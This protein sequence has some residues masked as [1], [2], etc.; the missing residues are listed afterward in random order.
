[1]VSA[2]ATSS[3]EN[4]CL[5]PNSENSWP[6]PPPFDASSMAVRVRA[7]TDDRA[8]QAGR[9]ASS[10]TTR[11]RHS[12]SD[13]RSWLSTR[14]VTRSLWYALRTLCK[15]PFAVSATRCAGENAILDFREEAQVRVEVRAA[16]IP[17]M[18]G[19]VVVRQHGVRERLVAEAVEGRVVDRFP[20]CWPRRRGGLLEG[21]G[22]R[23]DEE[24]RLAIAGCLGEMR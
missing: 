11:R 5:P 13:S 22:G 4:S 1:M 24:E 14:I 21:A 6:R 2:R 7:T 3:S 16:D 15:F 12:P 9:S 10:S 8:T 17:Q 18:F 23:E 20:G 19:A